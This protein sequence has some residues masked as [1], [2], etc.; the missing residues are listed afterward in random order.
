MRRAAACILAAAMMAT[1]VPATA[2]VLRW[3]GYV[4]GLKM[5]H[6]RSP[7]LPPIKCPLV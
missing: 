5:C 2:P 1:S 6:T 3:I 4:H 7:L